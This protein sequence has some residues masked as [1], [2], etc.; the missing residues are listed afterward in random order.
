MMTISEYYTQLDQPV[1]FAGEYMDDWENAGFIFSGDA[2][3]Y[4]MGTT[5]LKVCDDATGEIRQGLQV[6]RLSDI[7]LNFAADLIQMIEAAQ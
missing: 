7:T 6:I 2:Y 3:Y 5:V 4:A 1:I